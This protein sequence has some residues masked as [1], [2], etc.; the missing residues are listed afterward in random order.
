MARIVV[1]VKY[2]KPTQKRTPGRYARYIGTREGVA[3][4][5]DSAKF[6][7]P[8]ERDTTYADYIATRPRA[9]RI[10]QHGLFT[11]AGVEVDLDKVS[12]ELNN[13]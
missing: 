10:G 8:R 4:I 1:K 11:D 12:D 9:E 7:E 13:F 3:K 6:H 2:L 5:D